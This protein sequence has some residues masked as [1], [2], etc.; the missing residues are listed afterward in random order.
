MSYTTQ[1]NLAVKTRGN[2]LERTV[3][4]LPLHHVIKIQSHMG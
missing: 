2:S 1:S 3:G 4:C